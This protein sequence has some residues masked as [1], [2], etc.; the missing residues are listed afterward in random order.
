MSKRG[1]VWKCIDKR[2]QYYWPMGGFHGDGINDYFRS[3]NILLMWDVLAVNGMRQILIFLVLNDLNNNIM[4]VSTI[5][6]GLTV[7]GVS[8]GRDKDDE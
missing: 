7:P 3:K 4:M 6:G 1:G 5:F 2:R 8:K